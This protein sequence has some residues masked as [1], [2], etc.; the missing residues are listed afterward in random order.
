MKLYIFRY[1]LIKLKRNKKD[2]DYIKVHAKTNTN[3]H[4]LSPAVD[5]ARNY[6]SC[7]S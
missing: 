7:D 1:N 2:C 6:E 3:V 5:N 4:A